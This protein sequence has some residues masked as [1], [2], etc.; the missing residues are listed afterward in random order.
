MVFIA[1]IEISFSLLDSINPLYLY[2]FL[3]IFLHGILQIIFLMLDLFVVH[4]PL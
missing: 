1:Y 4:S 3:C 2:L